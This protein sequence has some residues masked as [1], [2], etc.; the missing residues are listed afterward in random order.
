[1]K[2]RFHAI[3]FLS[4]KIVDLIT[5]LFFTQEV[6]PL[7]IRMSLTLCEKLE[8]EMQDNHKIF[9]WKSNVY[10]LISVLRTLTF[11]TQVI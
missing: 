2:P 8:S 1:M 5:C 3:Q 9:Y 7:N 4:N 10:L 11:Q 6:S